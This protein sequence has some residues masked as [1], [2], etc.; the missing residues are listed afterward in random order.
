M[1][2]NL[3]TYAGVVV[4]INLTPR[5]Y[6]EFVNTCPSSTCSFEAE[7]SAK[8]CGYCGTAISPVTFNR[9]G[10]VGF[11]Q[12]INSLPKDAYE[13][14]WDELLHSQEYVGNDK[15]EILIPDEGGTYLDQDEYESVA[16]LGEKLVELE[17]KFRE[18]NDELIA[19][20]ETYFGDNVIIET[21]II[22]YWS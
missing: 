20:L 13:Q 16:A 1:S 10:S 5:D 2:T 18:K 9:I 3:N 7:T 6:V 14:C 22:S 19:R 17:H 4:R 12:F 8:F 11:Q 15:E 21:G